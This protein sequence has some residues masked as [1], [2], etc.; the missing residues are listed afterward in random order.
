MKLTT[1]RSVVPF[2]VVFTVTVLVPRL[3]IFPVLNLGPDE[4]AYG[5]IGREI[6][7]GHWPYT[8]AFDHKPVALYF[9]FALSQ[10]IFG[11]SST[12]LRFLSL[13]V[14]I[15]SFA[16]AYL[17]CRRLGLRAWSAALLS[18]VYALMCLGNDGLAALSEPI[19]NVYVLGLL[20]ILTYRLTLFRG[21]MF[22]VLMAVAINTN[23]LIGPI[24]VVPGLFFLFKG[25]R[26]K[27]AWVGGVLGFLTGCLVALFPIFAYSSIGDYFQLQRAFLSVYEV[28]P[29]TWNQLLGRVEQFLAPSL[30]ILIAPVA[31]LIV[32]GAR[33]RPATGTVW[34]VVFL[35]V[36]IATACYNRF[37]YP[38]YTII[39]APAALMI[40]AIAVRRLRQEAGSVSLPSLM[41]AIAVWVMVVPV[42]PKL[43]TGAEVS[44]E[45]LSLGPSRNAPELEVA[46][47]VERVIEPGDEIYTMDVHDYFLSGAR[48]PTKFFFPSQ[49]LK[50]V[51]AVVMNSTPSAAVREIL[52]KHPRAIV[53]RTSVRWPSS[54]AHLV[55]TYVRDQCTLSTKVGGAAIYVCPSSR[56]TA[57]QRHGVGQ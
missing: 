32:G 33:G 56:A 26:A 7:H 15:T 23:Y 24:L 40:S 3:M 16:L 6:L 36:S 9:P 14:A 21:V 48:L 18:G 55:D 5:I 41:L 29:M 2:M 38:H 8:T 49:H 22:G 39:I 17:L 12:A 20:V 34:S 57:S 44:G 43:L 19:L 52:G 11:A 35:T 42:L 54:V 13:I 4:V 51:N 50:P 45:Q 46:E 37:F 30:A 25:R 31:A 47:A 1:T 28:T 53:K 10:V 27:M